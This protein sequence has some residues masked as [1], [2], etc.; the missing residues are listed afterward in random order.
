[1]TWSISLQNQSKNSLEDLNSSSFSNFSLRKKHYVTVGRPVG[2]VN[3]AEKLTN[4]GRIVM[5]PNAWDLCDKNRLVGEQLPNRFF[6]LK[7]LKDS[8]K[9]SPL[10]FKRTRASLFVSQPEDDGVLRKSM[11][12]NPDERVSDYVARL[13]PIATYLNYNDE[14][15]KDQLITEYEFYNYIKQRLASQAKAISLK[16]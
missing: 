11:T 16:W 9:L 5:S 7:F 10:T 13:R 4:P 1:M 2:E 3:R 12:L 8:R 15:I 14:L 6:E